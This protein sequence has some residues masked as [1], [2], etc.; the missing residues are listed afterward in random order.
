MIIVTGGAGFIGSN[1]VQELNKQGITDILI[2]D[3]IYSEEKQKNLHSLKFTTYVDKNDFRRMI[4]SSNIFHD[5][6]IDAI[7]HQGA[8]SDTLNNYADYLIDNNYQYSKDLL[9]FATDNT[10]RFIYASSAAVYGNSR[11]S[12]PYMHNECPLNLYGCYKLF[13]DNYVRSLTKVP[14][15]TVGLRYFNVYGPREAHK[16]RM[17]STVFQFS[18]QYK[19]TGITKLFAGMY[20]RDFVYVKDVVDVNLFFFKKELPFKGIVNV[21]TG[22]A[23]P[24]TDIAKIVS[25]GKARID[26]VPVPQGV[27]RSYQQFTKADL[28]SLRDAGYL[29]MM[30]SLEDGI[31]ETLLSK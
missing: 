21:G 9:K 26:Y 5:I 6:S 12:Q 19:E 29:T 23:R 2:V 14:K 3:N 7:I 25:D 11:D 30:T 18:K 20:H 15:L 22:I 24:F 16:G 31:K 17:A 4:N 8:C 27:V 10:D 13:F 1:I 28:N